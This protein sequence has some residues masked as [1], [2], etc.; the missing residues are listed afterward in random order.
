MNPETIALVEKLG[1][2]AVQIG[3]LAL[4]VY[5]LARTLRSQYEARIDDCNKRVTHLEE[6][7]NKCEEDR[8]K[9]HREI[10]AIQAERIGIL[11]GMIREGRE[12]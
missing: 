8:A 10:R 11:E 9:M 12:G 6:R 1:T 7:S 4:F 3:M 5:Y 2:P